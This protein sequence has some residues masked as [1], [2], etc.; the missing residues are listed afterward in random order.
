MVTLNKIGKLYV[1][2]IHV[3]ILHTA[4]IGYPSQEA[5]PDEPTHNKPDAHTYRHCHAH[6]FTIHSGCT[7][8]RTLLSLKSKQN[9]SFLSC[10]DFLHVG[11]R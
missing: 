4:W 6:V 7:Y 8:Q 9:P 3:C 10:C 1:C 5:S 11:A 2:Q